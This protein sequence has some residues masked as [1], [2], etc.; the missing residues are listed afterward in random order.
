MTEA[1]LLS[2]FVALGFEAR[3]FP[4]YQRWCRENGHDLDEGLR[5][6]EHVQQ[7]LPKLFAEYAERLV[8]CWRQHVAHNN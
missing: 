8:V 4:L 2:R 6:F 3:S 7:R 5:R 1:E